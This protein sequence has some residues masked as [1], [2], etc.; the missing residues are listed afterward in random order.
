MR[1]ASEFCLRRPLQ[2]LNPCGGGLRHNSEESEGVWGE[3]GR[4]PETTGLPPTRKLRRFIRLVDTLLPLNLMAAWRL[5]LS[6]APRV[7]LSLETTGG[8]RHSNSSG[9]FPFLGAENVYD[10]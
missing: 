10:G 2:P 7:A 5:R 8:G 9:L 3:E 4:L 6:G 1:G